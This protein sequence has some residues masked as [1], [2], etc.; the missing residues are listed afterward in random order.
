MEIL[1]RVLNEKNDATTYTGRFEMGQLSILENFKRVFRSLIS[2]STVI[3]S[4]GE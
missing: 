4:C 3:K 2:I 1:T